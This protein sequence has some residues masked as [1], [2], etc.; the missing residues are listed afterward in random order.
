MDKIES[1]ER[2]LDRANSEVQS[3]TDEL[4]LAKSRMGP[5]IKK[6]EEF[7][8]TKQLFKGFF[9]DDDEDDDDC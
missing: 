8:R 3:L 4:N 5:L 1:M 6:V 2:Q 7:K 9:K